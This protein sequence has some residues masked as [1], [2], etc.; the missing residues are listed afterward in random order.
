MDITLESIPAEIPV[1]ILK[2]TGILDASSY[3]D[4]IELAKDRYRTGMRDLLIDLEELTF[5]SSSG[6]FAMHSIALLMR[7]ELPL[8]PQDGWGAFHSAEHF[9]EAGEGFERHVKL[10]SPNPRVQKTLET[11]NFAQILEVF[12]NR[13]AAIASFQV[14]PV[15]V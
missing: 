10:L 13:E 12:T 14:V 3:L 8:D 6:I 15:S 2:L 4:L 5:M 1:T 9:V 7:G 11:T